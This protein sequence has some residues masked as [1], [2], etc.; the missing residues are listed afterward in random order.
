MKISVALLAAAAG[1]DQASATLLL[2]KGLS[3][4]IGF[5]LGI[6][7]TGANPFTC[8]GNIDNKCTPEWESG[9]DFLDLVVGK[10]VEYKKNVFSG[11]TCENS[12]FKR[13]ELRGRTFLPGK[14]ITGNCGHERNDC[15]SISPGPDAGIDKYSI[16]SFEVTTSL[17]AR[18]EFH[19]QMPDGGICKTTHDCSSQGT[20]VR[21]TQCGGAKKVWFVFP[22]QDKHKGKTFCKIGIHKIRWHCKDN[23]PKPT[24]S[25]SRVIT[26]TKPQE[27]NTK[28]VPGKDTTTTVPGQQTT[29]TQ[30][31]PGQT[32]TATETQPGETTPAQ[33]TPT[34][35]KPGETTPAQSTPTET[36]PGE[37]TTQT[38]TK[39]GETTPGQSTPTET[40]PGE[41]TPAQSTPTETKP[42]ETTP[43]QSTPTETKPGESTTQTE[44]KPGET[45][46]AQST[47]TETKPRETTPAQTTP[48]EETTTYMTTSTVFTTSVTTITSCAPEIPNCPA[49][50][51]GGTAIVTVTIPVSTTICP[52]TEVITKT[53]PA[54]T[55][56]IPATTVS[57]PG[58]TSVGE[59]PKPSTSQGSAS[60][61]APQPTGPLPC[62]KVVPQCLNTK[63]I[64]K[65]LREKCKDNADVGCYCPDKEFIN[66]VLGCIYS[67]GE[68]D[69]QIFEA[70]QFL[71]GMCAP[72]VGK[73]PAVITGAEP[74][75]SI[76]TVTGT[77]RVTSVD[78]T[79]VVIA[80]TVVEPC[81]TSGSTI[82]GSSTTRTIS[83]EV[84]VPDISITMGSTAAPEVPAPTNGP[85]PTEGGPAENPGATTLAPSPITGTGGVPVPSS[86]GDVPV[87]AGAARL[88]ASL[89][90]GLAFIAAMVAM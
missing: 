7:F 80:T 62:P 37:S 39:P 46:P 73:N 5:N 56:S 24:P 90:L 14:V 20:T 85:A 74:I 19:Y 11:F 35:T 77:P 17:D 38:E 75:T 81:V 33:S 10:V 59:K 25:T 83:T 4:G 72:W 89:G 13:G 43:A 41:T 86:T 9:C 65:G 57:P 30:T 16:D 49:K 67:Y 12:F 1:I 54:P 15:P 44:T 45:T 53:K 78:Y 29:V 55:G 66:Q 6:G 28:T 70:I 71:Q 36:K 52:V 18:M 48:S 64:E 60:S 2:G 26:Y 79:T 23:K 8:P 40:K 68:N 87:T 50:S 88:G 61:P 63:L 34:E 47:P 42:G 22:K 3:A 76:I 69:N 21:N 32:T 82:P 31:Q 27:T 84:T 51:T 58:E